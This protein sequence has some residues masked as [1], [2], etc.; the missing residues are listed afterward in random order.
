M[1]QLLHGETFSVLRLSDGFAWGQSTRS[2]YVGWASHA[3]LDTEMVEATHRVVALRTLVLAEPKVRAPQIGALSLNALVRVE[4]V[5]DAFTRI[6][7]L[8]WAPSVHFARIGL[9]HRDAIE[10]AQ[11]FLG[12]PYAWGG[13]DSFGLDC[14]GLVQQAFWAAGLACP[15]DADQQAAL[16]RS[17]EREDL[18]DGDLV[19][20]P[21]HIGMMVDA[22]RIIHANAHHMAVAIEPVAEAIRRIEGAA[23][24]PTGFRRVEAVTSRTPGRRARKP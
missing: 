20:W 22:E 5:E 21:G 23:G 16:G 9:D 4:A 2:G 3:A 17:V 18:T 15:R 19:C 10:T 7:G 1:D 11:M 8:G 6:G 14:S 24:P 12:V 13:K